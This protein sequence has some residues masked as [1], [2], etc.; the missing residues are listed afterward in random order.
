VL[1]PIHFSPERVPQAVQIHQVKASEG[2]A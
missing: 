1:I 2:Q